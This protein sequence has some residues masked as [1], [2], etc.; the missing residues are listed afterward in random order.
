MA[1]ARII[2]RSH[3]YAQQL[4]LDLLARGYTVEVVSPEAVPSN[5]ADLELRV[6]GGG[7]EVQG[8]VTEIREQGQS[9]SIEYLQRLKPMMADLLRKWPAN[10]PKQA[11][12]EESDEFNFNAESQYSEE[13]EL[14]LNENQRQSEPAHIP[15]VK[16]EFADSARLLSPPTPQ[17]PSSS[18]NSIFS[19]TGE[20]ISW[21]ESEPE[22][23]GNSEVW[24]WRAA[25]G[26]ACMALLILVLG[27]A[28]R[29]NPSTPVQAAA[30]AGAQTMAATTQQTPGPSAPKPSAAVAPARAKAAVVPTVVPIPAVAKA[31]PSAIVHRT[32][33]RQTNGEVN[34]D[35]TV[36][37]FNTKAAD[38]PK[39]ATN[40]TSGIKHYSDLD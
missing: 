21:D 5:P 28:L 35:T 4:A 25:V 30:P 34:G 40:Q 22:R 2:T 36:T 39:A 17:K 6:E 32:R 27:M 16:P 20:P 9:K 31:K 38:P 10:E 29:K 11:G 19:I 15:S 24:F 23:K 8:Q 3:Q 12:S 37:Y 14:P 1:L 26:F 33:A 7:T 13:T 18:A